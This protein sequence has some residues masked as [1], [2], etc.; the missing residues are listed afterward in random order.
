MGFFH[1]QKD[2]E[3]MQETVES[4]I[5]FGVLTTILVRP[6]E[7]GGMRSYRDTDINELVNCKE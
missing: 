1:L 7:K 6:R 4:I 5:A 3:K 2:D